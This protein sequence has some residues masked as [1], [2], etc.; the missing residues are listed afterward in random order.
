LS[1][2]RLFADEC[3]ARS[4]VI[5]LRDLGFD[6][7]WAIETGPGLSDREQ[8]RR[9][10]AANRIAISADYDFAE[11]AVRGIEPFVG[12][13]MLAPDLEMEGESTKALAARIAKE[14]PCCTGSILIFDSRRV[15][16]RPL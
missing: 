8:A 15:R 6:V 4:L 5:A 14:L 16:E 2:V 10:F 9:A 12:L 3:C 11:L 1:D 7:L 13:V